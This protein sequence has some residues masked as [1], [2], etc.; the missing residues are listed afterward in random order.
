MERKIHDFFAQEI[1]P[2][3]CAQ[4]IDAT[5]HENTSSRSP[6]VI[7]LRR[8]LTTAAILVCLS[9]LTVSGFETMH[10]VGN[11][12]LESIRLG[13]R[14]AY[15]LLFG[16]ETRSREKIAAFEAENRAME[17]RQQQAQETPG[18]LAEVRDGRLY[19]IAQN[20]GT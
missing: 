5:L 1:M 16:L 6:R 7:H 13:T 2:E 15:H 14:N 9:V 19:F 17:K 3:A 4:Q 10:G 11:R 12:P 8:I 20:E 18:P